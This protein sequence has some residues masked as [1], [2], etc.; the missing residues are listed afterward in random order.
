V[1]L[2]PFVNDFHLE[3]KVILDWEAFIGI[4]QFSHVWGNRHLLVHTK[5]K[6]FSFFIILYFVY[7][8]EM[9]P[10]TQAHG[11]MLETVYNNCLRWILGVDIADRHNFE[12]LRDKCQLPSLRWFLAQKRLSWLGC[13][14]RGTH[15]WCCSHICVVP[16]IPGATLP[17]PLSPQCVRTFIAGIPFA[18]GGWYERAQ[19]VVA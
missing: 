16:S 15:I 19:L 11:G 18:Q 2:P 7:G 17:N 6:V 3:T 5:V 8:N 10:L 1:D 14:R 4:A 12:H 9:W 13:M